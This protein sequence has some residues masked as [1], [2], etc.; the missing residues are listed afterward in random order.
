[1]II[2]TTYLELLCRL[3]PS[4]IPVNENKNK[5]KELK[6]ARENWDKCCSC[7]SATYRIKYYTHVWAIRGTDRVNLKWNGV[8]QRK[9]TRVGLEPITSWLKCRRSTNWAIEPSL[10][11]QYSYFVNSFVRGASQKP[12]NCSLCFQ[13][14]HPNF[15]TTWEAAARESPR[16]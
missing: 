10:C 5:Y 7:N 2:I 14:S 16:G 1:M 13:G 12:Y 15:D 9:S 11:W 3:C 6:W 4:S 8:E